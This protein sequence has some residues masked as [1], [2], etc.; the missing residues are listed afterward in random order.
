[1]ALRHENGRIRASCVAADSTIATQV[2]LDFHENLCIKV[3]RK[4]HVKAEDR[5]AN[6]WDVGPR[7]VRDTGCPR[8]K[9]PRLRP[10]NLLGAK[11]R[12][13]SER[14]DQDKSWAPRMRL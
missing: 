8:Q 9:I 6:I 10:T 4:D 2:E 12:N 1:M 14:V 3:E 5:V 13:G 11:E 7:G